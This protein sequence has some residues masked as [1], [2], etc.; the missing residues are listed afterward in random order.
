MQT[1][2]KDRYHGYCADLAKQLADRMKIK[3]VMVPVN[4]SKYGAVDS[5]G[6]WNGM[7]GELINKVSFIDCEVVTLNVTPLFSPS[8]VNH[9]V[10]SLIV[11]SAKLC[12]SLICCISGQLIVFALNIHLSQFCCIVSY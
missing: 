9:H 7:V 5:N 12:C 6:N 3:Y 2:S 8:I 11:S 10:V 4:D 1:G